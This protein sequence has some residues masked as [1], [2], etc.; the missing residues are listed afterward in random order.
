MRRALIGLAAAALTLLA[1]AGPAGAASA[2]VTQFRFHGTFAN[3][4]WVTSSA[5]Q[6]TLTTVGASESSLGSELFADRFTIDE[7]ASGAFTGA[8][9]I[10]VHVT[11]G[12][13]FSISQ[14]LVS[15]SVSGTGLPATTCTYDA[16]I[17]L[18]GCSATTIDLAAAW[19]GQGPIDR[20]VTNSHFRIDGFSDTTHSNGTARD[21]TATGTFGGSTLSADD[22]QFADL[23]TTTSGFVTVCMGTSC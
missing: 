18:I 22:L 13:S 4:L 15:A 5:T 9:D 19:T 16:N 17:A 7:D 12:F 1:L 11:S 10:T 23:G 20:G 2:Q 14:P 21:A 3:A 8:T 6:F